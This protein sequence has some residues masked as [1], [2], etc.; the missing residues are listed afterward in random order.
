MKKYA[1]NIITLVLGLVIVAGALFGTSEL[2][3]IYDQRW[4]LVIV[5]A[6]FVICGAGLAAKKATEKNNPK[7]DASLPPAE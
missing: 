4:L 7:D 1:V 6:I 3:P 5:G 2:S